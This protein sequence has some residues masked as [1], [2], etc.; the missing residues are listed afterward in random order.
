[1]ELTPSARWLLLLYAGEQQL[2]IGRPLLL[3][4][5]IVCCL[6]YAVELEFS[7]SRL[8]LLYAV[9]LTMSAG[10]QWLYAVCCVAE[11]VGCMLWS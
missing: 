6:Q 4:A 7:A 1:M 9:E 3:Y 10:Q 2:S 11:V 8:L 5:A